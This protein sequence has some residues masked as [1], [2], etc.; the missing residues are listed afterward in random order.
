[1]GQ[2]D[3]GSAHADGDEV[4]GDGDVVA[5]ES[6]DVF[7]LLAEDDDENGGRAVSGAQFAAVQ[8]CWT[9]SS[10]SAADRLGVVPMR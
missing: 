3:G 10:C 1:V 5:G 4:V 2:G 6:D 9:A 8:V 7:D